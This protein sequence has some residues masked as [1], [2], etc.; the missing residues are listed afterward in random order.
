MIHTNHAFH[1][2]AVGLALYY[3]RMANM[4]TA[5]VIG[6]AAAFYMMTYGHSLPF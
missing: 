5:A 6:G 1:G 4:Q 3:T 2:A